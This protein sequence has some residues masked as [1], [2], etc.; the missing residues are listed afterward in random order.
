MDSAPNPHNYNDPNPGGMEI[1]EDFALQ[2]S[3]ILQKLLAPHHQPYTF[4][5]QNH[6]L[7]GYFARDTSEIGYWHQAHKDHHTFLQKWF[8]DSG[9]GLWIAHH[10]EIGLLTAHLKVKAT[11]ISTVEPQKSDTST[12]SE[13]P[14]PECPDERLADTNSYN[15]EA[16]LCL[17]TLA[18]NYGVLNFSNGT[19]TFHDFSDGP[20]SLVHEILSNPT[21]EK[22]LES[23]LIAAVGKCHGEILSL[24]IE[25]GS[26][27][28]DLKRCL[29]MFHAQPEKFEELPVN[30]VV[31]VAI[32]SYEEWIPQFDE[33][34]RK[35]DLKQTAEEKENAERAWEQMKAANGWKGKDA[36]TSDHKVT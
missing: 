26:I 8:I 19:Y 4:D 16:A 17:L 7:A 5:F 34:Q 20:M 27:L 32:E 22:H 30:D 14:T 21:F 18:F 28:A 25:P 12:K 31:K 29:P 33:F 6:P 15:V 23:D 1:V 10:R 35:Q 13:T 9:I 3:L 24:N 36:A 2:S 11:I